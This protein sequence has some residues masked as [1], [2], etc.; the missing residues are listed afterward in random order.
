VKALAEQ[1][2]QRLNLRLLQRRGK[3]NFVNELPPLA[4]RKLAAMIRADDMAGIVD[5]F[6]PIRAG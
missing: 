3:W 5:Y 4:P 6:M 2:R 1:E